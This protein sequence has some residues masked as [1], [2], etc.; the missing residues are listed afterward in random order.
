MKRMLTMLTYALIAYAMLLIFL[1]VFQR[2][3]L[4]FPDKEAIPHHYFNEFNI[5]EVKLTTDD[6]LTLALLS[7]NACM[8]ALNNYWGTTTETAIVRNIKDKNSD[9]ALKDEIL[10]YKEMQ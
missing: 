9:I 4:Y 10:F 8:S 3:Y 7:E 1:F 6:G 5:K 2:S